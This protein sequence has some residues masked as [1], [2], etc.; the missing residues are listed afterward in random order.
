MTAGMDMSALH[1]AIVRIAEQEIGVKEEGGNNRGPR[2]V[3]YQKA[4]WLA[5]DSWPWCAAFCAWVLR[6]AIA[7][8]G[9][10]VRRCPDASAYGWEK[11]ARKNA[12]IVLDESHRA[13]RGDFVTFDFSHIG[14][15]I[16]DRGDTIITVEGNTNGKGERDSTGGDGVWRKVRQRPLI[17]SLIRIPA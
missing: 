5:P 15:V 14:I 9:S 10:I 13:L 17:K 11:W 2:I 3:E 1:D 8:T 4:T 12:W 16:E 6:E 7:A